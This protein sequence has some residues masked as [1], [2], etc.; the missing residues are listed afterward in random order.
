MRVGDHGHV[1]GKYIGSAHQ[2][3]NLKLRLNPNNVKIPVIFHNLRG[4]DT[5]FIMQEIGKIG[6]EKNLGINC[7]PNNMERYMAFT[8]D[9]NLVFLESFQFMSSSLDRLAANLPEDKYKYISGVFKNEQL[10]LM[11]KKGVYPYD[12]MDAF[13]KFVYKEL[14]TKDEFF[15]ILTQEGITNEQCRMLNKSGIL[16]R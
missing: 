16:F 5:H 2:E 13:D 9:N 8:M 4:Y 11:K 6:K 12:F 15:S 3:Y 7:I 14:P 10:A 1:T